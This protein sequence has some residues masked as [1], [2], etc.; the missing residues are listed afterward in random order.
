MCSQATATRTPTPTAESTAIADHIA[1]AVSAAQGG[2]GVL[3]SEVGQI[4]A[5]LNGAKGVIKSFGGVKSFVVAHNDIIEWVTGVDGKDMVRTP[6]QRR[7]APRT[8]DWERVGAAPR[9]PG[10]AAV[11]SSQSS[12]SHKSVVPMTVRARLLGPQGQYDLFRRTERNE[13]IL[14]PC[15]EQFGKVLNMDLWV[16]QPR[17]VRVIATFFTAVITSSTSTTTHHDLHD[18]LHHHQ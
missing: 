7:T 1:N 2:R 11:A 10:R 14:R 12:S 18:H 15:F 4:I 13:A 5:N 16:Q 8:D 17:N 9:S 6:R 3:S